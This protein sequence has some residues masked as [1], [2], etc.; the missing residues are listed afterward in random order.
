MSTRA[1]YQFSAAPGR[2]EVSLYVHHDGNPAGAA[3]YLSAAMLHGNQR[4]GLPA[5][6]LRANHRA[7]F[8]HGHHAHDDTAYRWTVEGDHLKGERRGATA[9]G[10]ETVWDGPLLEFVNRHSDAEPLAAYAGIWWTEALLAA[11]VEERI[12][13]TAEAEAAGWAMD[14]R[15]RLALAR[16]ALEALA[17]A[18]PRHEKAAAYGA[19]LDSLAAR[20]PTG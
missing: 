15:N 20:L 7:E 6:F 8:T 17:R 2:P 3:D 5:A 1:T 16:D 9:D 10:W 14:T 11:R 18:Y 12:E 4:G 13:A 19:H